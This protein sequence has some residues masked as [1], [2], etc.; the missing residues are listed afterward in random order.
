ML[1]YIFAEPEYVDGIGDIYPVQ[2]KDYDTFIE[3]NNLL[4]ISKQN[5]GETDI[6]LLD[7]IMNSYKSLKIT[8]EEMIKNFELLFSTVL[9]KEVFFGYSENFYGF[10][11]DHEHYINKKNYNEIRKIIMQQNLLFERKIYKNKITQEW[12]DKA[13][14]AKMK[15]SAKIGVEEMLTTV[16]V[17][18]GVNYEQLKEYSIYQLYSDFYRIR[19]IKSYDTDVSAKCAG[20]EK[21]TIEDFAKELDLFKSPYDSLFVSKEKVKNLNN[22]IEGK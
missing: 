6:P 12:A 1:K 7:L 22:A 11:A 20:A 17:Y 9:R 13:L 4:Y 21:V 5:F 14:E 18:K 16:S 15:N 2:L 3:C 10:L 19:M 8:T